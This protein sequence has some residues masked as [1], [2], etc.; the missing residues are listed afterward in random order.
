MSRY[1]AICWCKVLPLITVLSLEDR[2]K[3]NYSWLY[4][5]ENLILLDCVW[6][7][8]MKY[9]ANICYKIAI[10]NQWHDERKNDEKPYTGI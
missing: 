8:R 6:V 1:E 7:W 2:L 3:L 4:F 5:Q 10:S 9:E